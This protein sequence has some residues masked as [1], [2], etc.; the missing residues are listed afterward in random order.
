[1]E[2]ESEAKSESGSDAE[3]GTEAEAEAEAEAGKF[4]QWLQGDQELFWISGKAG[5]G[6]ST[7]MNFLIRDRRTLET[8]DARHPGLRTLMVDAFIWKPGAMLQKSARGVLCTL[9]H[10]ILSENPSVAEWL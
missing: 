6:K 1:S 5:S 4:L 10:G 8:L 2:A 9:I 7:L 3:A